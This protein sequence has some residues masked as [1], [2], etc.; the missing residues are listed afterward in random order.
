MTQIR[1]ASYQDID[2]LTQV[3][4][5]AFYETFARH[6][7]ESDMQLYLSANFTNEKLKQEFEDNNSHFYVAEHEEEVAGYVKLRTGE[8][9]IEL[10]GRKHIEIERIYVLSQF[11]GKQIGKEL[12]AASIE[13]ARQKGCE[14]LWLGVW[15]HNQK[16][17][18]FYQKWGFEIFGSHGFVLGTDQQTDFLMKLEL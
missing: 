1:T 11:Q 13:M 7:T 10:K 2:T 8:E 12:M 6:N 16:A 17:I 15:E 4:K 5:Q 9:P 3:G 14:V 18:Q